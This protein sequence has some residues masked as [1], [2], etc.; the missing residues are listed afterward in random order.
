MTSTRMPP[1]GSQVGNTFSSR[2]A[3]CPADGTGRK[4]EKR[5]PSPGTLF[6]STRPRISDTS[7]AVIASPSPNP[8]MPRALS[9]LSNAPNIRSFSSALIPTPVS[10]TEMQSSPY[11]YSASRRTSPW[12]V[13]F[14]ALDSRLSA[15]CRICEPS[16]QTMVSRPEKDTVNIRF[17]C[18][19]A[20]RW[21]SAISSNRTF[22]LKSVSLERTPPSSI[23]W[24]SISV[25]TRPSM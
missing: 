22:R 4:T 16:Q 2:G 24:Y 9:S 15:I 18:L 17:F 14:R 7:R 1:G 25:F 3:D 6:T 5:L 10:R 21:P 8:G 11:R 19:A 12:G 23:R 13:N 20:S